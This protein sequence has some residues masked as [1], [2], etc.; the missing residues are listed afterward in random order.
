MDFTGSTIVWNSSSQGNNRL[1]RFSA[2]YIKL[3]TQEEEF[4]VEILPNNESGNEIGVQFVS[5]QP[6][7]QV[8]IIKNYPNA[9]EAAK[10]EVTNVNTSEQ[11]HLIVY[12]L[13]RINDDFTSEQYRLRIANISE[14]TGIED[15]LEA[16]N[17]FKIAS[18]PISDNLR[19]VYQLENLK[20]YTV[21]VTDVLGRK[22]IENKSVEETITTSKW[23]KGTYFVTLFDNQK[24]V[25]VRKIVVQ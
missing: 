12:R 15:N 4:K 13:G 9:G 10:I 5:F 3:N 6:N 2:D 14:V 22:M 1:M 25:A 20:N 7:G 18:N 23:A 24:P 11:M 16:N 19:F 17:Y 21:H 8:R